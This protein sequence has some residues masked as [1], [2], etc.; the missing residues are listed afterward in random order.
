MAKSNFNNKPETISEKKIA[1]IK[2]NG[3]T[4]YKTDKNTLREPMKKT[5]HNATSIL[6][7]VREVEKF[8]KKYRAKNECD[9]KPGQIDSQTIESM[10]KEFLKSDLCKTLKKRSKSVK[11]INTTRPQNYSDTPTQGKVKIRDLL[12]ALAVQRPVNYKHLVKII[13]SWDSRRA[14]M[15]NVLKLPNKEIYY[16]TDGQ[17]TVLAIAIRAAL[18]MFPDVDKDKW[19]DLEVK[20]QVVED[21]D[22][23]FA[24]QHFLGINGGDKLA[25]RK[26]DFWKNNVLGKR[27]DAWDEATQTYRITEDVYE[28]TCAKQDILESVGIIPVHDRDAKDEHGKPGACTM[29]EELSKLNNDAL[30]FIGTWF[31][32]CWHD[33]SV[34]PMQLE[35]MDRLRK[36]FSDKG[37]SV[38]DPEVVRTMWE[39]NAI[40]ANLYGSFEVTRTKFVKAYDDWKDEAL[41]DDDYRKDKN[42]PPDDMSIVL[43]MKIHQKAGGTYP[44]PKSLIDKYNE[45][46]VDL[47]DCLPEEIR[48]RIEGK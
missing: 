12:V 30:M 33:K 39:L 48:R 25:L 35:P 29:V 26:F 44:W 9:K 1:Y 7:W 19:L 17:H 16:I 5:K 3:R 15:P 31:K 2:D 36:I 11:V 21:G 18:G 13:L 20:C 34:D 45:N 42:D 43:L 38:N 6:A 37:Y 28:I 40:V 41:L 46:D 14:Q 24:R 32:N 22:F 27:Q 8:A 4:K 23:S 10:V 47:Y